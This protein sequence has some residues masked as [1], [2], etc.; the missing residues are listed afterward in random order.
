MTKV[1]IASKLK[2]KFGSDLEVLETTQ[3]EAYVYISPEKYHEFCQFLKEDNEFDFDYL[4]Q[5]AG[6]HYPAVEGADK[7]EGRFEVVLCLSSHGKRHNMIIKVK[8]DINEPKIATTSDI[9]QAANWYEREA[10]ELFGIEFL[11]HP[12]PRHLMLDDDWDYGFP[13]RKGW[14]GPNFIPMPEK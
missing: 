13:M 9:W 6:V 12:D 10:A 5:L 3:P 8:L 14:T 1:E 4:F 2:D 11:G 7:S